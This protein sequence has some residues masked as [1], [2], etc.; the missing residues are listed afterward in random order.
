ML[1]RNNLPDAPYKKFFGRDD[2]L[3]RISETLLDG[4]TFIASIDGIG[5]IGKTALAH[6]FCTQV[7]I[8]SGKFD[9]LVW[10]SSKEDVFDP[11]SKDILIKNVRDKFRGV[12]ELLDSILS[13]VG[14]EEMIEKSIEEKK[15]FIENEI[16]KTERVFIV[17]DNLENVDDDSFF[18]YMM[19][20]FNK[21]SRDNRS[22]KILTT[23][24]K[25]KKLADF[26]IEIEGLNT[27]DA[28]KMLKFLA[29]EYNIKDIL[30][31]NDHDNIKLL[32]KIGC[33]PLGIEFVVG[34][35][36]LGKSRGKIY[37][38]LE[39]FPDLSNL[40]DNEEK[41][42]KLSDIILFSY[43]NMYE[44][45]SKEQQYVFKII[46]SLVRNRTI[47]DPPISFE[48]LMTITS[49]SKTDLE[50]SLE[51]LLDNK[52][53]SYRQGEY[54]VTPMS[55]NFVRQYYEDFETIED[56]VVETK[57]KI[58][59]MGYKAQDKVELFLSS[60]RDL[61]DNNRLE[62]AEDRLLKALEIMTDSRIYHRLAKI[63]KDLNKFAKA[64]DSF[65]QAAALNPA[66]P[67][68]WWD[69]IDME[70]K[71]NR[72][73]IALQL[74]ETALQK[75][76]NDIS[77]LLQRLN[78]L[79]YKRD[80][81]KLRNEV[82]HYLEV[83]Q[84]NG[85][86]DRVLRLLRNWRMIE[87]NVYNNDENAVPDFYFTAT[88]KLIAVE[89][90]LDSVMQLANEALKIAQK[91]GRTEYVEEFSNI[92]KKTKL[93]IVVSIPSMI[94]ELHKAFNNKNYEKAKKLAR[95]ILELANDDEQSI[96]HAVAALRVLL[97]IL[98]TE[99]E[100]E[101]V[102][103]TFED[104]KNIGFT[105]EWQCT[106]IYEKAKREI[107]TE[108]RNNLIGQ[109]M[110]NIQELEYSLRDKVVMWALDND[111]QK[112][113][114]LVTRKD[115]EEWI[116]R[117]KSTR[118]RSLKNDES[119]IHF[120]DLS[121]LRS[122]LSW[123]KSIFLGKIYGDK[124]QESAKE[125]FKRIT[126]ELENFINNE[127]NES[128]HSRLQLYEIEELNE[129]LVDTQRTLRDVNSLIELTSSSDIQEDSNF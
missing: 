63:Q 35:M 115:K 127:R 87:L 44:T 21:F 8:P 101:R 50:H 113:V 123:T 33:I 83:Y 49:Y 75:T 121:D 118:T 129:F 14:L 13:V 5:G 124:N 7:V 17:L 78:I 90:N 12:E 46:A 125:L 57:N 71:K 56:S 76:E 108:K 27:E 31:A 126:L 45:L 15:E 25:R 120:S 41:R 119:L 107:T 20:S 3:K 85:Q 28:L 98:A 74:T 110:R 52:L 53:I 79:K 30:N 9:Y 10:I 47:N 97:Q 102:I 77:I 84:N 65:K 39:G 51:V 55:I 80:F 94:K 26:P 111:E 122:L 42:R 37:Q 22:L 36:T 116:E 34:Q 18:D 70:D 95:R 11:F 66:D 58:I 48:L 73:N 62:E 106:K 103:I 6:Y 82:N 104:Y 93:S 112:L 1:T 105:D 43:K 40:S 91:S 19:K 86:T 114:D 23:S 128:F 61:I 88:K 89:D 117:W 54:T 109:I 96:S 32:D 64:Q 60:L 68:I 38:E 4:G 29:T 81:Q 99:K 2:S 24:R 59:E 16:L 72:T 69:W 100:Y 92:I 67:R